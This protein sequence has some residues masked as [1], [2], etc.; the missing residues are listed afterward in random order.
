MSVSA[1]PAATIQ[2]PAEAASSPG[3]P[4]AEPAAVQAGLNGTP[5]ADDLAKSKEEIENAAATLGVKN[6]P[7]SDDPEPDPEAEAAALDK[8]KEESDRMREMMMRQQMMGNQ[9]MT[10]PA[11]EQIVN[12]IAKLIKDILNFFRRKKADPS[13]SEPGPGLGAKRAETEKSV[14]QTD[15]VL[16][17]AKKEIQKAKQAANDKNDLEND[18]NAPPAPGA[19]ATA[20]K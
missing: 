18:G 3:V 20:P 8:I 9:K 15:A 2:N 4:T 11:I 17:D 16:D 10:I 7:N 13:L 6:D 12:L 14:E 5:L 1:A 19:A